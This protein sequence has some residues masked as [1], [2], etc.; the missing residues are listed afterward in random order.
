M[1]SLLV[2]LCWVLRD[3][4]VNSKVRASLPFNIMHFLTHI[5]ATFTKAFTKWRRLTS[6]L[7]SLSS[8][9]HE[10]D[11]SLQSAI[12]SNVTL[13]NCVLHPFINADAESQRYQRENL[14][15]IIGEGAL[16]G[17]V[18]F[19][20]PNVWLFGWDANRN[21]SGVPRRGMGFVVWPGIGVVVVRGGREN[22][23]FFVSLWLRKFSVHDH[24]I[25]LQDIHDNVLR[26]LWC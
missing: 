15:S 9:A 3:H 21:P 11:P 13:L 17:M 4:L 22:V 24:E 20:Q 7:V 2:K 25:W 1:C 10:T 19:S 6:F 18:I 23:G 14:A 26:N 8:T 12:T 16:F 5:T